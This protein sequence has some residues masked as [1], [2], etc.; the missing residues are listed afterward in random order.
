[1]RCINGLMRC[2]ISAGV[3]E[4]GR[5]AYSPGMSDAP[6][7]Q[8]LARRYLD[9][10][11]QYLTQAASDPTF[12]ANMAKLSA[13]MMPQFAAFQNFTGAHD[14]GAAQRAAA[15]S[16]ASDGGGDDFRELAERVAALE[17]RLD[18]AERKPRGARKGAAKGTRGGKS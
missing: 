13:A 18:A 7:P 6:D 8:D 5:V 1:M 14:E 17:K 4:T 10:W 11:Q 9:L 2:Q 3:A 15:T 16:E 12:A